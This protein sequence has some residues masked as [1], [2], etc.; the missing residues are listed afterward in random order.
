MIAIPTTATT[1]NLIAACYPDAEVTITEG[2][3]SV[4]LGAVVSVADIPERRAAS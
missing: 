3:M 4:H 2:R 1:A